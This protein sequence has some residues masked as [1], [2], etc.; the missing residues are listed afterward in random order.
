MKETILKMNLITLPTSASGE[1]L[2]DKIKQLW[3]KE[4][5]T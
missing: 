3:N 1:N 2:P 4:A 5:W